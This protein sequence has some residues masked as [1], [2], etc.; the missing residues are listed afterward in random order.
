MLPRPVQ[1]VAD[2][3]LRQVH[4]AQGCSHLFHRSPVGDNH[5]YHELEFNALNTTWELALER[6]YKDGGPVRDPENLDG[7][8]SVHSWRCQ[9]SLH[10][11]D[12]HPYTL[13]NW[14]AW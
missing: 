9:I 5:N 4:C 12:S 10:T 14:T 11:C 7:L 6:P 13:R 3:S 1:H 8:V 2:A